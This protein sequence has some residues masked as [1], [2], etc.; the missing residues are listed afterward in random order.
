MIKEIRADETHYWF[1]L[2][3]GWHTVKKEIFDREMEKIKKDMYD[4]MVYGH[5]NRDP[6]T[7]V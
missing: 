1:L 4:T 5:G 7:I 2:E 3:N 6:K